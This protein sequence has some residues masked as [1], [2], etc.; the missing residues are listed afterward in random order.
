[1]LSSWPVVSRV[2]FL[3]TTCC[4]FV[5]V[6]WM[7]GVLYNLIQIYDVYNVSCLSRQLS[8][9]PTKQELEA[10]HIIISE[11]TVTHH[12]HHHRHHCCCFH[13]LL[14]FACTKWLSNTVTL[15]V[16]TTQTVGWLQVIFG[17]PSNQALEANYVYYSC[18][19]QPDTVCMSIVSP[20]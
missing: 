9:R 8:S 17:W 15:L 4:V 6:E 20:F 5:S 19:N 12:H 13:M 16:H 18:S 3:A 1:M 2:V 10:K 11:I 7:P 14:S